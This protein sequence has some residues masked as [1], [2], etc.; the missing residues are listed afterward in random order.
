MN[1]CFEKR[2]KVS[3]WSNELRRWRAFWRSYPD[4]RKE[5]LNLFGKKEDEEIDWPERCELLANLVSIL[6]LVPTPSF[7]SNQPSFSIR[8]SYSPSFGFIH[9]NKDWTCA[10]AVSPSFLGFPLHLFHQIHP[11]W[12]SRASERCW[13][14]Q[15]TAELNSILPQEQVDFQNSHPDSPSDFI[16]MEDLS[17]D[18]DV[19]S[20]ILLE[21]VLGI[22]FQ[23]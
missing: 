22:G 16:K 1:V 12:E 9:S 21:W 6:D 20:D 7:K 4:S 3:S 5:R 8:S 17:A 19:L 11:E 23:L 2:S 10:L 14:H 18:D 15:S 13:S